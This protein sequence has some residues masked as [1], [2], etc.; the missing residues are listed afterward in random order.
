[1]PKFAQFGVFISSDQ[2]EFLTL[3]KRLEESIEEEEF[4]D[5]QIMKAVVVENEYG[6]V[7]MEKISEKI[8]ES[9]IYVGIFGRQKSEWT[10]EEYR[11]AR[12][13]DLPTLIY[14]YKKPSK[15][16]RP[17][18]KE[19]RGRP[20]EVKEFLDSEVKP[21]VNINGYDKPYTSNAQITVDILNHLAMQTSRMVIEAAN[22]RKTIHRI[23]VMRKT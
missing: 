5:Q 12:A 16:G 22:V 6:P 3:R 11:A 4:H 23:T 15:R 18:E 21:F 19:K 17:R 9:S 8:D 1:M 7:N 10:F 20:S 2:R 13:R 14:Y